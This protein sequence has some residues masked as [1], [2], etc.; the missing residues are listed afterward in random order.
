MSVESREERMRQNMSLGALLFGV[1]QIYKQVDDYTD[2]D[3]HGDG[4]D[5]EGYQKLIGNL[6]GSVGAW[7]FYVEFLSAYCPY[8]RGEMAEK[9]ATKG[10]RQLLSSQHAGMFIEVLQKCG[11][12][13]E[14]KCMEMGSNVHQLYLAVISED[15]SYYHIEVMED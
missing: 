13:L 5:I 10:V 6:L 14:T 8:V 3:P 7:R 15:P 2:I 4:T 11:I 1:N 12:D 9:T